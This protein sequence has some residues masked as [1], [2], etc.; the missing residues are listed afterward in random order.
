[1]RSAWRK[2]PKFIVTV[3][4]NAIV[5][6][7]PAPFDASTLDEVYGCLRHAGSPKTLEDMDA[8]IRRAVARRAAT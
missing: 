6:S 3:A 4:G 2:A 1:M 5:L 8:G 7:R